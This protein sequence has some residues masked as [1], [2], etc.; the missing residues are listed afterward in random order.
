MMEEDILDD[1]YSWGE[2]HP[3]ALEGLTALDIGQE[4]LLWTALPASK[5]KVNDV[6]GITIALS[7]LLLTTLL[8]ALSKL[9]M[10]LFVGVF[11]GGAFVAI[12]VNFWQEEQKRRH[13]FYGISASTVWVKASNQALQQYPIEQFY[14]LRLVKDNI[15]YAAAFEEDDQE[16]I[17][18]EQVPQARKVLDLL[19]F[20]HKNNPS[21]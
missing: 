15:I 2:H 1:I 7:L 9:P 11:T 8:L 13:T 16:G 19:E 12:V 3:Q 14:H 4:P 17:L 6:I 20:L 21:S 10:M 5:L 18:L